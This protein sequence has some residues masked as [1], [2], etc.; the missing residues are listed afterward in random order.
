MQTWF[1]LFVSDVMSIYMII[2]LN[3]V[4]IIRFYINFPTIICSPNVCFLFEREASNE[5]YGP[6]VYLY[7]ILKLKNTLLQ[8]INHYFILCFR[9]S[10]Y[11]YNIW[12]LK[13]TAKG[14]TTPWSRWVQVFVILCVGVVHEVLR[15]SPNRLIT[16]VLNWG[17]YL[18]YFAASPFPLQRKNQCKLKK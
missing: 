1:G 10:I 13:L 12:S 17:K 8:F 7:H 18:L 6:R 15:G 5:N 11:H 14:L 3:I 9:L 2:V 4:I 16:L